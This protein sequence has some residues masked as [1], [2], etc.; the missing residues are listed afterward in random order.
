MAEKS[1][2]AMLDMLCPVCAEVVESNI[3]LDKRLKQSLDPKYQQWSDKLCPSCAEK[4]QDYIHLVEI[5]NVSKTE[6]IKPEDSIRTGRTAMLRIQAFCNIFQC[7][8]PKEPYVFCDTELLD[9]LLSLS[10]ASES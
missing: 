3:L 10:A 2:V 4:R 8:E 5:S 6:R 1:H 7:P 9:K